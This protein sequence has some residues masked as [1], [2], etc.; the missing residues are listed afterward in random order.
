MNGTNTESRQPRRRA[1][2]II[3]AMVTAV[4]MVGGAIWRNGKASNSQQL[5]PPS[6]A[7]STR[8]DAQMP[9][10]HSTSGGTVRLTADQIRQFGV[11]FGTVQQRQL[12]NEVRAAGIV[13]V[14][15]SRIVQVSPR[16]GGYVDRLRVRTS[17]E[18]VRRGQPLMDIYSPELVAA[19]QELLVASSL[20]RSVG[21][22]DIPGVPVANTDLVAAAHQRLALWGISES[23]ITSILASGRVRRTLTLFAPA[24]GVVLA[25]NVVQGQAVQAGQMLYTIAD[26]TSVWVDAQLREMDAASVTPG[27]LAT[28][29]VSALPGR[30][31]AGRVTFIYPTLDPQTRTARGR[32]NVANAGGLLKPG[33]YAT[34]AL[35]SPSRAALTVPAS[36]VLRTGERSVVFV[37]MGNGELMPHEVQLG[38][39][40]GDYT[41]VLSGVESGQRVA[42]SAQF[43]LDSESNLGEVMRSMIGQG[44]MTGS[45][46]GMGNASGTSPMG[47]MPGMHTDANMNDR[48]AD[49][50]GMSP[51]PSAR[52]P[53]SAPA[54]PRNPRR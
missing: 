17:G 39:T 5:R 15:S 52:T 12:T 4:L 7:T 29:A 11:T 2:W 22:G 32:V 37:D 34:V 28:V 48:G 45:T 13:T 1:Y 51:Q 40:A 24:S 31:F 6:G 47:N 8:P 26:L 3:A 41:E 54:S 10:M 30:P 21:R 20:Q 42:T 16:F 9:G 25:T 18:S 53:A 35:A 44:A 43:L 49:M 36:A 38:R 50:R 27:A 33:M 23:Q 19:Q 46:N 14:D